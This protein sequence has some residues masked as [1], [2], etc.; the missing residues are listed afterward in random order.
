[1]E[2]SAMKLRG[3]DVAAHV[4]RELNDSDD[5]V[6]VTPDELA[7]T[8]GSTTEILQNSG[9]RIVFVPESVKKKA[10]Q[11]SEGEISTIKTVRVARAV[12]ICDT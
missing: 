8:S 5:T 3:V 10:E 6:F 11:E 9:K 4:V 1:M 12:Y 2:D 7:N